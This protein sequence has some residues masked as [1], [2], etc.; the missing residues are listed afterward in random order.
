MLLRDLKPI[1][2]TR[3]N[4]KWLRN[5]DGEY[6]VSSGY[7]VRAKLLLE[8]LEVQMNM[9]TMHMVWEAQVPSKL[10]VFGWRALRDRIPTRELLAACGIIMDDS[11][12]VCIFC[13]NT[14]ES[15]NHLLIYC[16]A[17]RLIWNKK[18][19]WVGVEMEDFED[20]E[21]HLLSFF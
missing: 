8:A 14:M 1:R 9:T 5:A 2:R 20:V 13:Y 16:M 15:L 21:N 6:S 19:L 4:F 12:T 17:S 10:Q 11:D 3:D 7:V 18:F